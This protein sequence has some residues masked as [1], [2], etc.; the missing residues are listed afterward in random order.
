MS[1]DHAQV[2][3][4]GIVPDRRDRL[5]VAMQLVSE[6]HFRRLEFRNIFTMLVRYYDVAAHVPTSEAVRDMLT[7]SGA[8]ASKA[9]LYEELYADLSTTQVADHEFRYAIEA[10][11][12]TRAEQLTGEAIT[13]AFEILERG[14]EVERRRLKG[15]RE[16]REFLYA[17][18]GRIDKLGALESS[19]EGDVRHEADDIRREYA[20]RKEH[21]EIAATVRSG[22]EAVD[23][24]TSGFANGELILVC[25]YTG[26]GKSMM[27]TQ[28]AWNA[29]V[30]QGKNVF[31]AT[32][33][34]V[35]GQVRRRLLA[36]HSRE[37]QFGVSAGLNARDIKDGTLSIPDGEKVWDAVVEDF[38]HNPA[39]GSCYVSQ[40]P[41]GATLSAV[42]ARLAR[43][44][45]QHRVDLVIIDYLALLRSDR[46]RQKAQEEYNDVI[47]DAK[48]LATSFDGGRG[49]PLLSPWAMSQSRWKEALTR[50]EYTLGSLAETSE[51]EKSADQIISLLRQLDTPNEVK[52]Q[53]LKNR[54][55][56]LP[57]PFVLETDYRCAYLGDKT[58][59]AAME[60][61][62][63]DAW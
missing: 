63:A 24:A 61:L 18:L 59:G 37:A 38:T 3:L 53:F 42:E 45:S 52:V 54:D 32:S 56:E 13:T 5:L 27:A 51:A 47:K 10:L 58:T 41:R 20:D 36:R 44:A 40:V 31:F 1:I 33:E 57:K 26:E 6:E 39:Y 17:E 25:A 30:R 28:T 50:G 23:V 4:A 49:V 29:C 22:I 34:T 9:I 55:G 15:H 62:M 2:V 43:Y 21:K 19:P 46:R 14:A 8:E 48:V 7:R 12:E 35:R 60:E 11:R 16:A